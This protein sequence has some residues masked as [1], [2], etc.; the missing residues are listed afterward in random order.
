MTSSFLLNTVVNKTEQNSS[1]LVRLFLLPFVN[2]FEIQMNLKKDIKIIINNWIRILNIKIGWINDLDKIIK[3]FELLK[4]LQG[5]EMS[6]RSVKFSSNGNTIVS[7][8]EDETIRIWDVKTGKQIKIL[9]GHIDCINNVIF[10]LDENYIISCSNDK[11]IRL[12]DIKT[13]KEK[14]K[15]EGHLNSVYDINISP[16][17]NNI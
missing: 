2:L 10:S 17:G 9:N 12:W 16:N 8:S 13:G 1:P 7:S 14:I 11:T 6:V 3:Y 5:H 4:I 15:L